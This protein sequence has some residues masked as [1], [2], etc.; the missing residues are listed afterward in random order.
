M[1]RR[2]A[3]NVGIRGRGSTGWTIWRPGTEYELTETMIPKIRVQVETLMKVEDHLNTSARHIGLAIRSFTSIYDRLRHQAEDCVID[4]ITALEALWKLD[5]ELSFRLAF[6]T[7][8][9]LGETDDYREQVFETLRKYY[10]IRSKIVH[11]STLSADESA[12]VQNDEPLREIVRRTL[13]AF[14]H[15]LA[16]PSEWTV[17]RLAKDPDPVLLHSERRSALQ[18]AMAVL[19]GDDPLHPKARKLELETGIKTEE[20]QDEKEGIT[21]RQIFWAV[22]AFLILVYFLSS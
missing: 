19:R 2:A 22:V 4:S 15:L 13:R 11:G 10:K 3:F 21:G 6:R 16:N 12:L 17:G 8:S 1:N 5:S 18:N 7:S 9:L 20:Q 14:I